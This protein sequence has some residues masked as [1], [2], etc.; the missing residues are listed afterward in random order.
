MSIETLF[1]WLLDF[2]F[3][4]PLFMSYTWVTGALYYFFY[5]E[6]HEHRHFQDPPPLVETPGVSF[7]VPCHD[8]GENA[9]E[10]VRSL[11]DQ[12]YPDFEIIAV[13]DASSDQTGEV[14]DRLPGVVLRLV[15]DPLHLVLRHALGQALGDDA[16]RLVGV[17]A[18]SAV[19]GGLRR[20][21]LAAL[22][23]RRQRLGSLS[24][25]LALPHFTR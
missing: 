12:D 5:R 11:L 15:P 7:I 20:A 24:R 23:L 3:Y 2:S 21:L 25:R 10:T 22:A 18:G 14:L 16:L 13:N 17:L 6:H 8:E 4:Y 19:E 1:A 9:L